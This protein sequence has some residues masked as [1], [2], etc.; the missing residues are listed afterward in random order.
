[1]PQWHFWQPVPI[2]AF[3]HSVQSIVYN[4]KPV[5]CNL[6][7]YEQLNY[8]VLTAAGCG[9]MRQNSLYWQEISNVVLRAPRR[10]YFMVQAYL[11]VV[12]LTHHNTHIHRC[13]ENH[14]ESSSCQT[15]LRV[16]RIE[17]EVNGRLYCVTL[18]CMSW[19]FS[20]AKFLMIGQGKIFA[21]HDCW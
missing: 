12:V 10:R 1:M 6:G 5:G 3:A 8:G 11:C 4:S 19:T 21:K 17:G 2:A 13:R 9:R 18:Y 16:S 7:N 15:G 20:S 14:L